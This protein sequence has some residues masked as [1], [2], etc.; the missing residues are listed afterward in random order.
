MNHLGST[1]TPRG[2]TKPE[3]T[4]ETPDA[5]SAGRRFRNFP[6]TAQAETPRAACRLR[7]NA[8][9]LH[10]SRRSM[11]LPK[12]GFQLRKK[13]RTKK[14][15]PPPQNL[16]TASPD[17]GRTGGRDAGCFGAAAAAD[18]EPVEDR[19]GRDPRRHAR[20]F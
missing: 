11:R 16:R 20:F 1:N 19:V 17:R 5:E 2:T 3:A 8:A 13:L 15:Y 14:H 9:M 18:A 12:T 7:Q 10:R 4:S 6:A